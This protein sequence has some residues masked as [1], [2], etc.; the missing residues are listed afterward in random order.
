MMTSAKYLM[1]NTT[2]EQIERDIE[3]WMTDLAEWGTIQ[4][5]YIWPGSWPDRDLRDM[6]QALPGWEFDS[7]WIYYQSW[8]PEIPGAI[9]R[10]NRSQDRYWAQELTQAGV[11]QP[12]TNLVA[13]LDRGD[14]QQTILAMWLRLGEP[15]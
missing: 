10:F 4:R 12:P 11:Y 5:P 6:A 3:S 9:E 13:V 8:D 7:A 1:Q 2:G 15:R 14:A